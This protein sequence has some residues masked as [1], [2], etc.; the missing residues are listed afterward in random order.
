MVHW[1][2]RISWSWEPQVLARMDPP[3]GWTPQLGPGK[4]VIWNSFFSNLETL[5]FHDTIWLAHIFVEQVETINFCPEFFQIE[6]LKNKMSL[7][8]GMFFFFLS[9]H[10]LVFFWECK[11][12]FCPCFLFFH[13]LI[14]GENLD[15]GFKYFLSIFPPCLGRWSNLKDVFKMFWNHQLELLSFEGE[16]RVLILFCIKEMSIWNYPILLLMKLFGCSDFWN[17]KEIFVGGILRRYSVWI[18]KYP[19]EGREFQNRFGAETRW[20]FQIFFI[21]TPIWGN[22]PFWLI[23]FKWVET[24]N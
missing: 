2:N 24:T 13:V 23:F 7:G 19:W 16:I 9:F 21:F 8:K 18:L 20:W 5:G 6:I 14:Q 12:C 3:R 15:G 22:D 4:V 10:S 1:L 17:Y 11:H